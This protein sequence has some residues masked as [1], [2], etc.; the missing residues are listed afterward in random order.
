MIE[1]DKLSGNLQWDV[2]EHL[3]HYAINRLVTVL[4]P[5]QIWSY[6]T[7]VYGSLIDRSACAAT[8]IAHT[9][10]GRFDACVSMKIHE[11]FGPESLIQTQLDVRY[12]VY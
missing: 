12:L 5:I 9:P 7:D 10:P 2:F 4:A 3:P 11:K 8:L 1:P 6:C